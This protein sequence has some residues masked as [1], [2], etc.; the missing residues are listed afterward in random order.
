[1]I[2]LNEVILIHAT[3]GDGLY[4]EIKSLLQS[5]KIRVRE[6]RDISTIELMFGSLR[7][8]YMQHEAYQMDQAAGLSSNEFSA[9]WYM[10]S[11]SGRVFTKGQIYEYVYQEEPMGGID[12]LIYCLI[13]SLRKKV[14]PDPR[15]PKYIHTI[16]GAGYKFEPLSGE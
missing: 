2:I 7:I 15:Q 16:R 11:N 3:G 8:N 1:M 4:E 14:E 12:N 9:L 6:I 10:A 5:K 13:R